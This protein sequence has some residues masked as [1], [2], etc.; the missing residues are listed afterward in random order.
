[1]KAKIIVEGAYNDATELKN[2]LGNIHS[3]EF[4][5]DSLDT[6]KHKLFEVYKSLPEKGDKFVSYLPN[7]LIYGDAK[8]SIMTI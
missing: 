5:F 1:M 3:S 8:A 2:R 7:T 4:Y 6:A